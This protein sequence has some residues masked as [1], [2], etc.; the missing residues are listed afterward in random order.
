MSERRKLPRMR[1]L[2]GAKIV[3]NH[4]WST[5]DCTVRNLTKI[6]CCLQVANPVGI[7][8]EFELEFDSTTRPC[9]VIWRKEGRLG[10]AF[11]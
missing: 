6:G 2:K 4:R 10:V 5:I 1:A 7:P 3:F 11:G 8:D 9:H